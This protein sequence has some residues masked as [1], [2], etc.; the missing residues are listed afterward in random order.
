[1]GNVES[2]NANGPIKHA[3]EH[4]VVE[5]PVIIQELQSVQFGVVTRGGGDILFFHLALLLILYS[6]NS[7][8]GIILA[9]DGILSFVSFLIVSKVV[10][11]M[12]FDLNL[13][14]LLDEVHNNLRCF[15]DYQK[16]IHVRTDVLIVV[17]RIVQLDPNVSFKPIGSEYDE[18]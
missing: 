13:V 10:F 9:S 11:W 16:S 3:D 17:T 2:K 14:L 8:L 18:S 7:F 1:M 15:I 4:L 5:M 6:P 12:S